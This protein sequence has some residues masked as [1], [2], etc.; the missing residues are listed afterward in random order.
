MAI[1]INPSLVK[2]LYSAPI[3][4]AIGEGSQ[5][6]VQP[7]QWQYS[8]LAASNPEHPI[9][10]NLN[11]VKFD[12]VSPIDTLKNKISKTV[13]LQSSPKSKLEGVPTQI[14]LANVTQSPDENTFNL[15]PQN[16]AVLLEGEFTS[17]YDKSV[18]PFKLRNFKSKGS[19]SKIVVI[20]DGDVIKNEVVRR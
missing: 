9:T 11:L 10:T 19:P 4:L 15:G 2:D 5:A 20:A 7:I 8:P 18:L 3:M 16:L 12:F 17:V 1:R 14:A 6:Q 13:L